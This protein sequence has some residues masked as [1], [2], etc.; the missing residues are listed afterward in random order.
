VLHDLHR[1]DNIESPWFVYELLDCP[2]PKDEVGGEGR[3]RGGMGRRD[4]DVLFRRIDG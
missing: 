3:V 4:A 2:M 1:T